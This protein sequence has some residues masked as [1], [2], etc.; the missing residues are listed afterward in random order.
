M[1][2][3]PAGGAAK[4]QKSSWPLD[5]V[6]TAASDEE[7]VEAAA[8]RAAAKVAVALVGT[9]R[10]TTHAPGGGGALLGSPPSPLRGVA[11]KAGAARLA[12][13]ES[14]GLAYVATESHKSKAD[15]Q[16]RQQ[17]LQSQE[18]VRASGGSNTDHS[19]GEAD[20]REAGGGDDAWEVDEIMRHT[21]YGGAKRGS[22]FNVYV[23]VRYRDGTMSGR[24]YIPA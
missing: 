17:R 16:R 19:D 21:V 24:E 10:T 18:V 15:Q 22:L 9:S 6:G 20:G 1:R 23:S 2:K 8:K 13:L 5:G 7:A 14:A 4:R 12:R 11:A 3:T